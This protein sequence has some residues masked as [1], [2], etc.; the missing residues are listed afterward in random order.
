[1][2]AA[3]ILIQPLSMNLDATIRATLIAT[4]TWKFECITERHMTE[5]SNHIVAIESDDELERSAVAGAAAIERLISDRNNLRNLLAAHERE[6][7]ASRADQQDL[8]R[9]FAMLYQRYIE[10]AKRVVSQLQQFDGA[11]REVMTERLDGTNAEA[12]NA[13][14]VKRQFDS[15][16]L[17]MGPQPQAPNGIN[18]HGQ[19]PLPLEP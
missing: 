3:A 14:D 7:A 2:G 4:M 17:P 8:K 12:T 10:L 9:Q 19:G 15:N 13:P 5:G 1:M 16:G 18:G 6:L 11:M